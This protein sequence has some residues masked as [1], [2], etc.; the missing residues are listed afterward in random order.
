[1]H[2]IIQKSKA[3]ELLNLMM[4]IYLGNILNLEIFMLNLGKLDLERHIDSHLEAVFFK[5]FSFQSLVAFQKF[6]SSKSFLAPSS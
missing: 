5:T 3:I 2:I 4:K 1:M 6:S